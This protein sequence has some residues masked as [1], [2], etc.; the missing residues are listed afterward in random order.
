MAS[1]T[2]VRK[3]LAAS[4]SDDLDPK[5]FL[6]RLAFYTLPD[7]ERNGAKL[8]RAWAKHGLDLDDLPEAR[9]PVH[10]FQSACASVKSRRAT[11]G[12]DDRIEV[13]TDEVHN[14]GGS[15]GTCIYQITVKVWDQANRVIEHEKAIRATFDKGKSEISFDHLGYKDPRLAEI[16]KAI[17]K[18]FDAN[19]KTVPGQKIRNAIRT[20]L[21]KLGAQNMRRKAGGVYFVPVAWQP[22]GH[23]ELTKPTL[24]GLRAMLKDLYGADADFYTIP[25]VND[26]G[27][28]EMVAKQFTLNVREKTQE[29]MV[30]ALSRVRKGKTERAV[31]EEMVANL[32]AER[33]RIAGAVQQ[34]EK[35]VELEKGDIEANLRDL[36]E[37]LTKLSD[38]AEETRQ[39]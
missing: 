30:K 36:D 29:L 3:I 17:R 5:L 31:R 24:D 6:G 25:V 14:N 7:E 38:F 22:N 33:R 23:A 15:K 4:E 28:Q 19:A 32:Y 20:T 35:L 13:V 8:V 26:E 34:F 1:P 16:E 10:V 27:A 12:N 18:N 21:L 9:Q 37:A 11:N 2:E 39:K